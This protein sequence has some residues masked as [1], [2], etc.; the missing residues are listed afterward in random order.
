M[1]NVLKILTFAFVVMGFLFSRGNDINNKSAVSTKIKQYY[2]DIGLD[3]D[4][5]Y[6]KRSHKR[7]K[8]KRKPRR[9]RDNR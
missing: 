2:F 1:T 4:A 7:R 8:I 5:L 6:K 9:G 3:D